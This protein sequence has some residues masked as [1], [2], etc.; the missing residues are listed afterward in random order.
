MSSYYHRVRLPTS[1][2]S[3]PQA[4]YGIPTHSHT[5]SHQSSHSP[6]IN[7]YLAV[8]SMVIRP[9]TLIFLI[10]RRQ[11]IS[12]DTRGTVSVA[13]RAGSGKD[14][15]VYGLRLG[16]GGVWRRVEGRERKR[17][18]ERERERQEGESRREERERGIDRVVGERKR[19]R[20][21]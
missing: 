8:I 14:V 7:P 17:E 4:S 12:W 16:Y 18:R 2:T 20:E 9:L 11:P 13:D 21:G 3:R 19:E 1:H 6:K 10:I 15:E 5:T